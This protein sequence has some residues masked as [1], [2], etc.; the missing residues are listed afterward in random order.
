MATAPEVRWG[1]LGTGNIA[2]RFAAEM[3]GAEGARL[4]AVASRSESKATAFA[5]RFGLPTAYGRYESL[6][7]SPD[8]DIVYVATPHLFHYEHAGLV[9]A[10]DKAVLVE[11]PFVMNAREGEAL[12]AEAR[13]RGLLLM[14]GLWTLCNP[15]F[16]DLVAKVRSGAIGRP[17]G[18]SAN[19]GPLGVPIAKGT[20]MRLEDPDVGGS[21]LIECHVYPVAIMLALAPVF[22]QPEDVWAAATFTDRHVDEMASILLRTQTG[23]VGAIDGGL[24]WSTRNSVVSRARL[25]GATGW[26]EIDDDLFNPRRALVGSMAGTEAL[27]SSAA[28]RGFAW[29]IEEA[30]RAFRAGEVESPLVPH[31]LSLDVIRL[32]DRARASAGI[33]VGG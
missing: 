30:G 25:T 18:F 1:I 20:G 32:L 31:R 26:I 8:I 28:D 14:D 22:S 9:L 3:A 4:V 21:F 19:V 5:D 11:K 17:R 13:Q 27:E 24:A 33:T 23:E 12:V 29:E 16:L 7:A 6:A 2:T 10:H 15:L